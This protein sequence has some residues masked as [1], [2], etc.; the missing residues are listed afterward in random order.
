MRTPLVKFVE[1]DHRDY[2]QMYDDPTG[3]F[4]FLHIPG[5]EIDAPVFR[6]FTN[7]AL[8][9]NVTIPHFQVNGEWDVPRHH[10]IIQFISDTIPDTSWNFHIEKNILAFGFDSL[11]AATIFKLWLT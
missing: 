10:Q 5:F 7:W 2:A 6:N 11:E 4:I 1:A 3:T 9:F 8:D